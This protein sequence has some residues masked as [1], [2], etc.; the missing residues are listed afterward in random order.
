MNYT[1]WKDSRIAYSTEG[2]GPSVVFVHGFCEDSSI[3]DEFKKNLLEEKYKVLCMDLQGFGNSTLKD[4]ASIDDMAGAVKATLDHA[5]IDKVLFIGHSMGG[6]AGLAFAEMYPDRLSGLGL[7]HSHPYADPEE[8]KAGRKKSIDFIRR[9][10]H[11]LFVKQLFPTLFTEKFARKQAF[12]IDKLVYRASKY[13]SEAIVN[14][15]QAMID[16][17]DRSEVL[18]KID[19]PV[20]FIIGQED[21]VIPAEFSLEQTHLPETASIHILE[22]I[23]HMGMFEA[24]KQTQKIVR[25][26][27]AFCYKRKT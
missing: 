6:Y 3:W 12:L 16:R 14:A 9:Q 25:D 24:E 20:L 18:R 23:A 2:R 1:D 22:H 21:T 7:F 15:L 26:F 11:V 13:S 19:F 4:Y 10:G 8:K 17:P 5:G 27:A